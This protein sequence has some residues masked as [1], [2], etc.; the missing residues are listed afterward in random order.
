LD[1]DFTPVKVP[2]SLTTP[3]LAAYVT[4]N[5]KSLQEHTKNFKCN[6]CLKFLTA[7]KVS[8]LRTASGRIILKSKTGQY[9]ASVGYQVT[10]PASYL[11][12]N[13]SSAKFLAQS[14]MQLPVCQQL[15]I[16]NDFALPI[17]VVQA[18]LAS[19]VG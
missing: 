8:N 1:I 17:H 6:F 7:S 3:T 18:T 15:S 13:R 9:K 14:R 16:G 10:V 5:R 19:Q 4:F 11:H 12:Y 2:P